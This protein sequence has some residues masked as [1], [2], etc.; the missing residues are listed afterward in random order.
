MVVSSAA[1]GAKLSPT[2]LSY[3]S[4]NHLAIHMAVISG[5]LSS[6]GPN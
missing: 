6:W 3:M 1:R 2:S 5:Y 4:L